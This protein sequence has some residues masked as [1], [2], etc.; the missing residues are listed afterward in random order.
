MLGF[1][2]GTIFGFVAGCS[3]K[4]FIKSKWDG[5]NKSNSQKT[6][7]KLDRGN[8][9]IDRGTKSNSVQNC[10]AFNLCSIQSTFDKYGV[11]LVGPSSFSILLETIE[12]VV[13]KKTLV[14]FS[15]SIHTPKDLV[16]LIEN[17]NTY[18]ERVLIKQTDRSILLSENKLN[19]ILTQNGIDIS[20]TASIEDKVQLIVS[21]Y[22]LKGLSQFKKTMGTSLEQFLSDFKEQKDVT[23]LFE[24]IMKNIN[25]ALD[26]LS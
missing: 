9:H 15:T 21:F 11:D 13:Y 6:S 3:L 22:V 4:D 5:Y 18:E 16:L 25:K 7:K 26:F 10:E 19:Q 24:G 23:I 17:E 12:R 2:L 20:D 8:I 14:Q 1:T